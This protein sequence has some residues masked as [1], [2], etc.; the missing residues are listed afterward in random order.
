MWPSDKRS[1][2]SIPFNEC[3]IQGCTQQITTDKEGATKLISCCDR[4]QRRS[5]QA[6]LLTNIL[7]RHQ[8]PEPLQS[9]ASHRIQVP[10]AKLALRRRVGSA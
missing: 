7:R 8:A 9:Q 4:R 3:I 2:P 5:L 6:H 1:V 10:K